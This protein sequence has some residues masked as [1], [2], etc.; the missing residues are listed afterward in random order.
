MP[1]VIEQSLFLLYIVSFT[2]MYSVSIIFSLNECKLTSYAFVCLSWAA[3]DFCP[4]AILLASI[5]FKHVSK[6]VKNNF[7]L[8][9][10]MVSDP[11][12]NIL[13]FL[14]WDI[15]TS[16]KNL[17]WHCDLV[18]QKSGLLHWAYCTLKKFTNVFQKGDF[19][20]ANWLL[21]QLDLKCNEF[22]HHGLICSSKNFLFCR[23]AVLCSSESVLSIWLISNNNIPALVCLQLQ[24]PFKTTLAQ[25]LENNVDVCSYH[26]AVPGHEYVLLSTLRCFSGWH[27]FEEKTFSV[28]NLF[29]Y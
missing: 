11:T 24:P 21:S 9:L 2:L 23:T 22:L 14:D 20:A 3:K 1:Q 27:D 7:L 5:S 25:N 4:R 16:K 19:F 15:H 26:R 6:D 28:M 18:L 8:T 12:L 17:D 13:F 10:D 29:S